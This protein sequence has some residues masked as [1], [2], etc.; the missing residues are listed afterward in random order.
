MFKPQTQEMNKK[1]TL[2]HKIISIFTGKN[3]FSLYFIQVL[4]FL[5]KH[6]F[7]QPALVRLSREA[8]HR[9]IY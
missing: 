8:R 2:A 3:F 9:N 1:F 5:W 6:G 4:P 7:I